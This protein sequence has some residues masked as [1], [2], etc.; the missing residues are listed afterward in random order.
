MSG[1]GSRH[2]ARLNRG[3]WRVVRK[4]VFDRDG[5]RCQGCGKPG[6]L[7]AHHVTPLDQGGAPFDLANLE[8]LC[9]DCHI[10]HHQEANLS[11]AALDWRRFRDELR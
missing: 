11:A 5:W 8:T 7:E 3:R 10:R 9:R 6:R 4:R 1:R 2:H